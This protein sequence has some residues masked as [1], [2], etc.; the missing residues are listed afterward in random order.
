MCHE[1][2]SQRRWPNN[3]KKDK[4]TWIRIISSEAK[5]APPKQSHRYPPSSC[6]PLQ[7]SLWS[8]VTSLAVTSTGQDMTFDSLTLTHDQSVVSSQGGVMLLDKNK[9]KRTRKREASLEGEQQEYDS[10]HF[11]RIRGKIMSSLSKHI[12]FIRTSD[13][14]DTSDDKISFGNNTRSR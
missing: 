12:S 4:N 3:K 11:Q 9:N 1:S 5:F 8:S 10:I 14:D 2:L 7:S 13:V 6:S